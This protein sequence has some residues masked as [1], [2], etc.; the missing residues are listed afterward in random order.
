MKDG[1]NL[2]EQAVPGRSVYSVFLRDGSVA[3]LLTLVHLQ[4]I[5]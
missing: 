3:I 5:F 4:Y 1:V 2:S